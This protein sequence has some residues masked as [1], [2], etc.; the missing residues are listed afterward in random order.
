MTHD[1]EAAAAAGDLLT[2][3]RDALA[4]RAW[5][6]AYRRF[7]AA[8]ARQKLAGADLEDLAEAARWSGRFAEVVDLLE[9][10]EAAHLAAGD[11]VAAARVAL[12]SVVEH[13]MRGNMAVA[14]GSTLRARTLLEGQPE[15]HAHAFLEWCMARAA[16]EHGDVATGHAHLTAAMEIA[17]RLRD[18]D[19]E[20]LTR[21]DLGQMA[22]ADGRPEEG[23]AMVDEAVALALSGALRRQ[24]AGI[25]YC[26]TIWAC[27]NRGDLQRAAEWTE[28]SSRWCA[29]EEVRGFPGLCRAHRAEILR[30][31][32]DLVSAEREASAAGEELRV[33]Y[34]AM[35]GFA[36]REIGDARLRRGDLKG[37]M[38]AY[39]ETIA[40]GTDPQPGLALLRL[41]EGNPEAARRSLAPSI[42]SAQFLVRTN[43]PYVLPA[44][45]TVLL[46]C[47]DVAGARAA[48]DELEAL[49]ATL[50][51]QPVAA[52][53]LCA[54]G[55]IALAERRWEDAL[56][57]LRH[58]WRI[59][60]D[61]DLLYEAA[62][63]RRLLADVH[64]G[65][66]DR[67]AARL[68]LEAARQVYER[69]G[70]ARDAQALSER[71]AQIEP[72]NDEPPVD[73]RRVRATFVFTDIVGSTALV[74]AIGDEAW[75]YLRLW[76]D[77]ALRACVARHRGEEI[78]HTGDGFFV[79]FADPRD[80][81][82]CAVAI[83]R[84]LAEHRREHGFA[85]QVRIGVH[86]AEVSRRGGAR[87]GRGVHEAA[88]IA[89][90]AGA[91]EVLVSCTTLREAGADVACSP[92]RALTLKG[93]SAP[94]EVVA[95]DWTA[96]R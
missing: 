73:E 15:S 51:T 72:Q 18:R 85:P 56:E 79:E 7:A 32:G 89:A 81:I 94:V 37:A 70:A 69:L 3:A 93:L 75:G 40:F 96:A 63:A 22:I 82:D 25:I 59:W 83:Q 17:R 43:K 9:R 74:E 84:T 57:L 44:W 30:L 10:A 4:R 65:M 67:E 95:L 26:G 86:A 77:R 78:D 29:R 71:L 20:A 16:L 23:Q 68:E 33:V 80:A 21:H 87:S 5:D 76:H 58:A 31:H 54:R 2:G 28:V 64:A 91:G 11:A 62:R 53:A 92:P 14:V 38:E 24:I 47:G 60:C 6:E 19:V 46:A 49:A 39:R 66:G 12:Q 61:I 8:D 36:W 90:A 88:R 42:T 50:G 1:G 34:P 52:A 41:S 55:E 27:R 48:A 35:A 45:T 13:H